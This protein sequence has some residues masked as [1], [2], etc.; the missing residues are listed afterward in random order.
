MSAEVIRQ[1]E[2][3]DAGTPPFPLLH[4]SSFDLKCSCVMHNEKCE[5]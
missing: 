5:V 4:G 3:P 1:Q 2:N